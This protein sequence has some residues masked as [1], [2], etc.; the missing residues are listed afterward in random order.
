MTTRS[1]TRKRYQSDNELKLNEISLAELNAFSN[2]NL[3]S[4]KKTQTS[5]VPLPLSIP[6][7]IYQKI[8]Y[9]MNL[10]V[11]DT[12]TTGLPRDRY[13]PV[14]VRGNWPYPVQI[15]WSIYRPPNLAFPS[16][17]SGIQVERSFIIHPDGWDIPPDSTV[18][19]GISHIH[20]IERGETL[21]NVLEQLHFDCRSVNGI[22]FHNRDFD[23][24]VLLH[25]VN[26]AGMSW[27]KSPLKH[28]PCLCTMNFGRNLCKLPMPSS[29]LE[30]KEG[31]SSSSSSS[32]SSFKSSQKFKAPRLEELYI[33]LF[34]KPPTRRLHNALEDVRVLSD[35]LTQLFTFHISSLRVE[36]PT[37]F[38]EVPEADAS[39]STSTS[40]STSTS[41]S[42]STSFSSF[43]KFARRSE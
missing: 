22:V 11:I 29:L 15:A 30:I 42:V 40:T 13:A 12:E 21:R 32:S 17:P 3:N 38:R 39:A 8:P 16:N 23:L 41:A 37:L 36:A 20:A 10:L 24:P 1:Q 7:P 43:S 35:C 9:N 5:S 31:S 28:L 34:K 27:M 14:S 6:I 19:H 26:I 4:Q 2:S 33:H 25:A 18:I